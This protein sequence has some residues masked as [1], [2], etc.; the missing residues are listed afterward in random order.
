M[1][2]SIHLVLVSQCIM[3]ELSSL[4]LGRFCTLYKE[5][6]KSE[7]LLLSYGSTDFSSIRT[8]TGTGSYLPYLR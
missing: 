5:S 6:K 3:E 1:V 8:G 4:G 7:I 2:R